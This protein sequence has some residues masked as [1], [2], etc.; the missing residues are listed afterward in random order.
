MVHAFICHKYDF[1]IADSF[2]QVFIEGNET[3]CIRHTQ[4]D[5]NKG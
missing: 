4:V 2:V 5:N 1:F 3:G